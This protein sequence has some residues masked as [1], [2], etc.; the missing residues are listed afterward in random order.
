MRA[1]LYARVSTNDKGQD[2][3]MQLRELRE[4]AERRGWTFEIFVDRGQSGGKLSR[5]ELDRMLVLCRKRKLD[6]V[7]VYRFD[8]FAR[9][10]KQLVDA[11]EEF[12]GLGIEF[13]SL[14]EQVD[15]STPNGKLLFHIFAAI[16][17]FERSLIQER[18]RSGLAHARAKGRI[19]GRPRKVVDVDK[20]RD[21]RRRGLAWREVA[22]M[23]GV[24]PATAKRALLMAQK[25]VTEVVQ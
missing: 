19:G 24:S 5:P 4:F 10:T 20:I 18:V 3:E 13:V 7:V 22:L 17:E 8:R 14:H 11:L 23:V 12:G 16:A 9:S 15:T 2:P 25:A 1:A 21:L 6:V